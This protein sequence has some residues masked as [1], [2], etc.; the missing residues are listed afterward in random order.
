MITISNAHFIRGNCK[1][2]E[3]H[4]ITFKSPYKCNLVLG[5][6]NVFDDMHYDVILTFTTCKKAKYNNNSII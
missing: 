1:W 2:V 4:H 3:I 5:F 6:E